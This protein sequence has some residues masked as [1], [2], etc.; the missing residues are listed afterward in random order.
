MVESEEIFEAAQERVVIVRI[1]IAA[2]PYVLGNY[3]GASST[4]ARPR[5]A[6]CYGIGTHGFIA[7]CGRVR[8]FYDN[9]ATFDIDICLVTRNCQHPVSLI[10]R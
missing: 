10:G 6:G 8:L 4:T 7:T 5:L 2:W 3:Q 9:P 1:V